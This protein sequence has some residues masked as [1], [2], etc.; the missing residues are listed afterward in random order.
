MNIKTL[1]MALVLVALLA[2]VGGS[3]STQ[4]VPL[5]WAED[6]STGKGLKLAKER[7][8][9]KVKPKYRQQAVAWALMDEIRTQLGTERA[10]KIRSA[11]TPSEL[12][13]YL[14]GVVNACKKKQVKCPISKTLLAGFDGK[15]KGIQGRHYGQAIAMAADD[16][17][18]WASGG[19]GDDPV[20]PGEPE[21][22]VFECLNNWGEHIGPCDAECGGMPDRFCEPT[23]EAPGA[24]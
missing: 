8:L 22:G 18:D 16:N 9:F 24:K 2:I 7:G 11:E 5:A 10:K 17:D 21:C 15:A 20:D 23:T 14:Q 12:H 19:C 1:K 3:V 4:V 13:A 6:V